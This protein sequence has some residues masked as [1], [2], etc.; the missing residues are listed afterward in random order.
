E[1]RTPG[2]KALCHLEFHV[3]MGALLNDILLAAKSQRE[4]EILDFLYG[5]RTGKSLAALSDTLMKDRFNPS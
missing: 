2:S 5:Q 1:A 4:G 3:I